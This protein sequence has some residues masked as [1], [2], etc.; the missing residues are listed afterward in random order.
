MK[1]GKNYFL[2]ALLGLS[3]ILPQAVQAR[4][5]VVVAIDAGHGGKDPGTIGKTLGIKEKNITL[6]ISKKLKA[7]LDKDS[8]FKG[9]LTRKKD[10]FI[11]VSARSEVAR[12]YKSN[13][14]VSIHVDASP[15]SSQA[16]GVSVFVLS[17]QRANSEM[18][19]W[20]E[21]HE[22]QSELL[23]DVGEVLSNNNEQYLDTTI[24]DLQFSHI[25]RA[26]YE[27]GETVL[28]QLKKVVPSIHKLPQR[29]SLSVLRSPDIPSILVETGFLSNPKEERAL[30]QNAY[31]QKIANAIYKGLIHYRNKNYYTLINSKRDQSHSRKSIQHHNKSHTAKNSASYHI[32]KKNETLFSIA[33]KNNTTP[34]KLRKLNRLKNN[35]I[36]VGQKLKLH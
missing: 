13:I 26:G 7:L 24:L 28:G 33:M 5:Q 11:K 29:A 15:N 22:K 30:S 31:Q 25:Q 8:R 17:N 34:K 32:V 20:L 19:K 1:I 2:I 35:L 4:E 21:N 10:N 16:R 27:L 18:G 9:I 6:S 36:F 3:F 23:G 12:K 14:F